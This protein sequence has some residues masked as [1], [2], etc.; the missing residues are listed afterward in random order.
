MKNTS[1]LAW[2]E[3]VV[4]DFDQAVK[5]YESAFEVQFQIMNID[6][7]KYAIFPYTEPD[8]GGALV[9]S[10]HYDDHQ[11]G[12]STILIYLKTDSVTAQ[13]NKIVAQGG[14]IEMPTQ[15]IGENG[16]IGVFIDPDN[17]YVGLW[18]QNP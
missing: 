12:P 17:N 16:F 10:K 14:R 3:I 8:V 2:F 1:P 6:D 9:C 4:K 18:S 11:S 5:F 7:E 15:S 13:L